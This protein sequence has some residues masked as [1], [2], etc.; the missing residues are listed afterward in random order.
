VIEAPDEA[1][2]AGQI[3]VKLEEYCRKVDLNSPGTDIKERE[4]ML[5]GQPCVQI[6][7]GEPVVMFRLEDFIT[8]LKRIKYEELKGMN[9]WTAIKDCVTPTKRRIREYNVRVVYIPVKEITDMKPE[10]Q[11]FKSEL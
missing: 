2:M 3:R 1:T 10:K 11:E 7:N 9:L 5:R 8:Y 6:E 4:R